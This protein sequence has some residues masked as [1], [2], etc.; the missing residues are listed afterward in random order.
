[1]SMKGTNRMVGMWRC[2]GQPN[3]RSKT[4]KAVWGGKGE[5]SVG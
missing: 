5:S 3:G 4:R 2:Q 1:M